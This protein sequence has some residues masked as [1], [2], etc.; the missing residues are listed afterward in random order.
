MTNFERLK[1]NLRILIIIRWLSVLFCIATISQIK[2]WDKTTETILILI[3][4]IC[5]LY[6]IITIPIIKKMKENKRIIQN[7]INANEQINKENQKT[8]Q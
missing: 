1:R 5:L 7:S 2:I 3:S 8:I 6:I 4:T